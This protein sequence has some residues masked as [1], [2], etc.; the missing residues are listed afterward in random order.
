MKLSIIIPVYNEQSTIENVIKRVQ[1]V[2]LNLGKE[3]IIVDDCST[4][5]TGDI[6]KRIDAENIKKFSLSE[7]MGKGAAL[8]KGFEA[9]TGDIVAIQDADMEYDPQE[10]KALIKPIIDGA[11]DV[12]YGSR[13]S[14]GRPQRVYM[15]WHMVGNRFISLVTNILY[16]TTFTDIETCYKVF[17]ADILKEIRLCSNRFEIEPELTAK[18][19]RNGYRIYELPISY[20]GRTYEEGKKITWKEGFRALWTLI[21]YRFSD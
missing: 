18:F 1:S 9:V 11:A 5:G 20:Y 2:S 14:G 10:F 3:I 15:F 17:R 21:R 8:R 4:D 6:L 16:N 13:L 12:V 19:C 7:N